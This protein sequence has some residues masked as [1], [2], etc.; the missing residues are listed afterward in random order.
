MRKLKAIQAG[1]GHR[2]DYIPDRLPIHHRANTNI[3]N[4]KEFWYTLPFFEQLNTVYKLSIWLF[5]LAS[6]TCSIKAPHFCISN[7]IINIEQHSTYELRLIHY[8]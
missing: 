6:N 2:A 3:Q 4:T 5:K 1:F 7:N 8:V